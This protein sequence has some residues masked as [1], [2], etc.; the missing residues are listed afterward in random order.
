MTRNVMTKQCDIIMIQNIQNYIS[1]I[2][3][4][5]KNHKLSERYATK[6]TQKNLKKWKLDFRISEHENLYCETKL[7]CI[8]THGMHDGKHEQMGKNHCLPLLK[9]SWLSKYCGC[10]NIFFSSSP[11]L[12]LWLQKCTLS[13]VCTM[14]KIGSKKQTKR[15]RRG[16]KNM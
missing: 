1:K 13:S 6:K 16:G 11:I 14:N 8:A 4:L 3:R 2:N 5:I 10:S 9:I 7:L 12:C 15:R